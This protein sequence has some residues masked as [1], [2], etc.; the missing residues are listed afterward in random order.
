MGVYLNSFAVKFAVLL[1]A[2]ELL[3]ISAVAKILMYN[4][5]L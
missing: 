1:I 2:N 5:V 4:K 3:K